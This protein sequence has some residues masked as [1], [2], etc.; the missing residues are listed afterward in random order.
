MP[1][2]PLYTNPEDLQKKI[3][4]YF[5]VGRKTNRADI[6]SKGSHNYIEVPIITITGLVRYCGFCNRAS[7]YDYEKK[8]EFSHTIKSARNRIEEVYEELLQ[9]GLGAGA[10]FA[11]KNFGWKDTPLIDQSQHTHLTLVK[12]ALVKSED[13]DGTG[14]FRQREDTTSNK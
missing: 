9:R 6:G 13:M 2:P 8:P 4:E 7:F 1:R 11:L 14:H 12:D 3:D 5:T 10:I